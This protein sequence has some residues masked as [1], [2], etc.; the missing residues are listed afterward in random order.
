MAEVLVE[1]IDWKRA[2]LKDTALQIVSFYARSLPQLGT[3]RWMDFATK[4]IPVVMEEEA[5]KDVVLPGNAFKFTF[6]PPRPTLIQHR[7]GEIVIWE[8]AEPK[9][10]FADS[11]FMTLSPSYR[12]LLYRVNE[13]I[14]EEVSDTYKMRVLDD[15][16]SFIFPKEEYGKVKVEKAVLISEH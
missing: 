11:T 2:N 7:K 10:V 15:P 8:Q 1:H 9:I 5:P 3:S 4:I 14:A 16:L 12:N 6:N 13:A